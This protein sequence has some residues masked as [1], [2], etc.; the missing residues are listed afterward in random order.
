MDTYR[1]PGADPA[2]AVVGVLSQADQNEGTTSVALC[3]SCH[4]TQPL[5]VTLG[6]GARNQMAVT[7]AGAFELRGCGLANDSGAPTSRCQ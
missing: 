3:Q 4:N 1:T 5:D 6:R 7:T 2:S